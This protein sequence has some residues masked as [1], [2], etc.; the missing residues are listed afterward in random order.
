MNPGLYVEPRLGLCNR[1]LAIDAALFLARDIG[2]PLHLVW[3]KNS[4][5]G[6]AF[7]DLFEVPDQIAGINTFNSWPFGKK[8]LN[9]K[10]KRLRQQSDFCLLQKRELHETTSGRLDFQSLRDKNTP[11]IRTWSRFYPVETGS[12]FFSDCKGK[13]AKVRW[14]QPHNT[15]P[16]LHSPFSAFKPI[17]SLRKVI[18]NHASSFSHTIGVHIRRTDNPGQQLS[19]TELF[20]ARM[21]QEIEKCP[22]T[23]FFLATD[24]P[25]EEDRLMHEFLGRIR[26]HRKR[27]RDRQ[28][29]LAI[30]DGLIDLYCLAKTER[31]F[32]T[33]YS[34]FTDTAAA[35]NSIP[36]EV[37]STRAT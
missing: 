30:E 25:A 19:P 34:T 5:I 10:L 29:K 28:K 23:N 9:M 21:R 12:Q 18:F 33:F 3:A 15:G 1:M 17:K 4:E 13:R 27:S 20:I 31:I 35:I 32:G 14:W 24:D 37:L 26:I 8:V 2:K 22:E 6:C 7:E 36:L 16:S 11:Y